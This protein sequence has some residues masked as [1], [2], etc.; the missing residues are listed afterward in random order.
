[1]STQHHTRL[2]S[3]SNTVWLTFPG[4]TTTPIIRAQLLGLG[5][6]HS[7]LCSLPDDC[8]ELGLRPGTVCKGRSLLDGD[9]YQFET[10]VR[11]IVTTPRSLRLDPPADIVRQAPRIYPRL[12]V[13]LSG[14]V[15]PMSDHAKILA[16]LPV[17]I[18]DLCPTGCQL[19][20]S[21]SAWPTVASTQVLLTCQLPSSSHN[22]KF[23]GK[24][25]WIDLG[26]DL[27]IGIQFQFQPGHDVAQQDLLTWFTSQQAKLINTSA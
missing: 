18:N 25:E 12:Q 13:D 3:S 5:P 21:A 10:T 15:R 20:V 26:A 7:L 11:E 19:T 2:A 16:V 4:D 23:Y 6:D 24:I 22:S 17:T 9:T 1:M 14:T 8:T 27:Q